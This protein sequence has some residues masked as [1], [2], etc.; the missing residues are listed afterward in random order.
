MLKYLTLWE[1]HTQYNNR[2]VYMAMRAF[3]YDQQKRYAEALRTIKEAEDIIRTDHPTNFYH[4][5]LVAY[6]N[7]AWIY[8]HLTNYSMVKFCLEQINKFCLSLLSPYLY[9][10]DIPEVEAQK[11]WSLLV[12]GFR[13][14]REA[15]NCFLR[16]LRKNAFCLEY[17][18][19]LAVSAFACWTS[20]Q[21]AQDERVAKAWLEMMLPLDP[22]NY[23]VKVYLASMLLHKDNTRVKYLLDNVVEHSLNP[24]VLRMAAHLCWQQSLPS[25]AISILRQALAQDPTYPML[26]YDLGLLYKHQM[27]T[28]PIPE[29]RTEALSSAIT[30][31]QQAIEL[32]PL[33]IDPKL[34][35]AKLY[36]AESP[37]FEE[38]VYLNLLDQVPH[39]TKRCQQTFYLQWGDFLLRKK[40]LKHEAQQQ[41][42]AGLQISGS[43]FKELNDRLINL[44]SI[45]LDDFD[46]AHFDALHTFLQRCWNQRVQGEDL[47]WFSYRP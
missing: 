13:N 2:G 34:E 40:G 33:F 5:F 44:A 20:S 22:H 37:S 26:H 42:M 31:F 3:L 35:L 23:E 11:G 43:R 16:A 18:A 28:A 19:G 10:V 30:N 24:E 1:K 29:E 4:Q 25:T 47:W 27:E 45:F 14:G 17:Q 32:D 39:F 7:Y 46:V 41:Y 6:G 9:T 12:G 21:N 38:E 36:G 15:K 8:Y